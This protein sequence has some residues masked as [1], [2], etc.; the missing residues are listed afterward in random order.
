MPLYM[1][2]HKASDYEVKP[3]V[4]EIKCNH[5]ADLDQPCSYNNRY[6]SLNMSCSDLS[7]FLIKI[8]TAKELRLGWSQDSNK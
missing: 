5:I 1:D 7:R 2:L 4:D 3:T 8:R 6:L